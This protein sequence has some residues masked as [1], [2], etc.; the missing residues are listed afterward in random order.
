M[1]VIKAHAME[2]V[3]THLDPIIASVLLV[4]YLTPMK[5]FV[6]VYLRQIQNKYCIHV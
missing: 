6:W 4:M 2:L 5:K 1:N 3:K